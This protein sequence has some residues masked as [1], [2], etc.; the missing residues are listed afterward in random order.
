M[1]GFDDFHSVT[2][3]HPS[4]LGIAVIYVD[5]VPCPMKL[6]LYHHCFSSSCL[7]SFQDCKIN[8][9]VLPADIQDRTETVR[10]ELFPLPEVAF[11]EHPCLTSIQ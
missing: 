9:F 7:C 5:G 8:D 2:V 10:M 1:D 11:L 3:L 4:H 6:S